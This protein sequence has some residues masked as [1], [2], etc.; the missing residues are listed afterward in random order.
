M[1]VLFLS[2]WVP[3]ILFG[4]KVGNGILFYCKNLNLGGR[5]PRSQGFFPGLGAGRERPWE[6]GYT[7]SSIGFQESL[8]LL[9]AASA[10]LRYTGGLNQIP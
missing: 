3:P 10:R 5:Q 2:S 6:R 9:E 7:G 8:R 4:L 1:Y